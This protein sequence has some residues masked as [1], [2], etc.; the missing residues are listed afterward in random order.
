MSISHTLPSS[1]RKSSYSSARQEN[2]VEIADLLDGA[3][4]RDTQSRETGHLFYPSA[5]WVALLGAARK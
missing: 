3:A 4:V 2:C 1:W 5:E